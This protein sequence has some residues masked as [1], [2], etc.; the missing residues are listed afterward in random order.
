ML[1]KV[2]VDFIFENE[3]DCN[4]FIHYTNTES[5]DKIL[6]SGFL[7]SEVLAKTSENICNDIVVLSYNHERHKC[8][9]HN[10]V[11]ISFSKELYSFYKNKLLDV[12]FEDVYVEHILTETGSEWDDDFERVYRIPTQF[13]QGYVNYKT[14]AIIRNP[15]FNPDYNSDKFDYNLNNY[16]NIM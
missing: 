16:Q 8:Y 6:E 12:K 3:T 13:I 1:T 4:I 14:G 9:G 15:K 11:I 5:A 2:V 7:F 10:A